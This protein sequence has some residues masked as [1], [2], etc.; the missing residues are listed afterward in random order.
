M[1][2]KKEM[3]TTQ[4]MGN[5]SMVTTLHVVARG[6]QPFMV[7]AF[8]GQGETPPEQKLY[9]GRNGSTLIL[10]GANIIGFLASQSSISCLRQFTDSKS[11][12]VMFAEIIGSVS[13]SPP[14]IPFLDGEGKEISFDGFNEKVYLDE[15]MARPSS[16]ARDLIRRPVIALPWELRFDVNVF[17][18]PDGKVKASMISDWII[19]GGFR[20]GIGA[21]RPLFGRFEAEIA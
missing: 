19:R 14:E 20:V 2:R 5:E 16:T 18:A 1:R 17:E 9:V 21:F 3:E 13:V 11:W 4:K 15:R 8:R 7:D 12:K 10:P 6:L